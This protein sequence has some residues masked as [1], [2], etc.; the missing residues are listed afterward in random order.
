MAMRTSG[1]QSELM[2]LLVPLVLLVGA[3]VVFTGDPG[4][5]FPTLEKNLWS[6]VRTVGTWVS[7]L[8]S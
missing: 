4:Q 7:G 2:I 5:F 3:A 1:R 8:F 6:A